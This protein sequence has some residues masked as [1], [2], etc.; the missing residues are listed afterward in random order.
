[1]KF[2]RSVSILRRG[3][4]TSSSVRNSYKFVVAG[5]GAG[6]IGSAAAIKRIYGKDAT[7][8][9]IEPSQVLQP[10]SNHKDSKA[11]MISNY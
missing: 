3:F 7:V 4:S 8:A 5:G 1:M 10:V 6:G 9:V 2:F 11:C